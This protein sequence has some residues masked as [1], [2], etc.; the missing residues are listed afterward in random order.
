MTVRG[1]QLF[2]YIADVQVGPIIFSSK[3]PFGRFES[4]MVTRAEEV[5]VSVTK[6]NFELESNR[7]SNSNKKQRL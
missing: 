1:A 3:T 7:G 2:G 6:E 4:F 5:R